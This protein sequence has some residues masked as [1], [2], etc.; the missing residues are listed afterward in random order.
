[1]RFLKI[2]FCIFLSCCCLVYFSY[3]YVVNVID[4]IKDQRIKNEQEIYEVKKGD[5]VYKIIEDLVKDPLNVYW[6]KVWFKLNPNYGSIKAGYYDMSNTVTLSELLE[7][8]R[9]GKQLSLN[10][11]IV[12]G[13]RVS[14]I[15]EKLASAKY[16]KHTIDTYNFS[17]MT[18]DFAYWNENPE[19]IFLPETY[20]YTPNDSDYNLLKRANDSLKEFL[21]KEWETRDE[22]VQ[23]K[24]SYEALILAS[25]IEKETSLEEEY[26]IVSAV[27]NNRLKLNMKLQ[28]DP[29]VIY[30]VRDRYNGNITKKD[31]NDNNP[32]NTYVIEG[33]PPT[34]IAMASKKSLY[35]A[36]HPAKVDYLYF[37]ANGKGGHVFNVSLKEHNRSVKDFIKL[38]KEQKR[39]KKEQETLQNKENNSN[40]R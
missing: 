38:Q 18:K 34:P 7:I 30:G 2:S 13:T 29:T 4:S 11:T 35:A 16:L 5:S 32:Y 10:F 39:L 14:T 3:L 40:E 19:G 26:P 36:L 15:I 21:E 24:T 33:L 9:S 25:I 27:F 6:Y 28:T 22:T 1:M 37:V 17:N 8:I 20:S 23:L 12:E 31:L